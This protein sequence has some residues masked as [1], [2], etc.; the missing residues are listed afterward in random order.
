MSEVLFSA[1]WYRVATLRPHLRGHVQLHRH[2]YRGRLCYV[3]QDQAS[4][5]VHRFSPAAHEVIGLMDGTRTVEAVWEAASA[6]LGDAAPTQ[7]D[8]IQLLRQLHLADVLQCDVP[9]DMAELL[10]RAERQRRQTWQRQLLNPWCIRLPLCDPERLLQRFQPWIQRCFGRVGL[11]LWLL[12]VGTGLLLTAMHWHDLTLDAMDHILSPHNIVLLWLVFPALKALHEWGHACATKA[13]GGEVHDMGLLLMLGI[14][15]PYVDASAATAFRSKWQRMIVGAAGMIVELFLASLALFM[16]LLIEPGLVRALLY[17]VIVIAGISTVLFN[18]NPL[19][20]YDGYYILADYLEMPNLR[21]RASA[22]LRYLWERYVFG[23]HEAE[24]ERM[25]PSERG[26]YVG[27]ALAAGLYRAVLLV[28]V[29]LYIAEHFL[30]AGVIFAASGLIT[31]VLTP[32]AN[33]LS[34]LVMSPRLQHVRL[35][36]IGVMVGLTA[37]AVWGIGFAPVPLRSLAQGVIWAPEGARVRATADGFVERLVASPGSRVQRGDVLVV[38]RDPVLESRVA[39]MQGRVQ[40]LAV[41]YAIEW[42][43]D[44]SQAEILKEERLLWEERLAQARERL[45]A[46]TLRS[47]AEGLFIVPQAADLPGQFVKRGAQLGYVLDQATLTARVVVAQEAIDLVRQRTHGIEVR[48]AERLAEPIP[49]VLGR[50]VPAATQQLPSPALSSQGGGVI[51]TEARD[52]QGTRTLT[53]FFQLDVHLP[54]SQALSALGERV[55]VR[56][57]HGQEPL[58]QRWYR[59]LRGLFLAR[60]AV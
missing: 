17:D 10:L 21:V 31:S 51:A 54:S 47:P 15:C 14:P 26:W 3:L 8:I 20:R 13:Y 27:Y 16:W 25:T 45:A 30:I 50:T 33:L 7:D 34:Y 46:L 28:A 1:V 18:G 24:V 56:F 35:R 39:V 38:C 42:L 52:L 4:Q 59:Q 60:L 29:A 11:L 9:P 48:L 19:L 44:V 53:R 40:E 43:K 5:R 49:A 36:A 32:G 12:V 58:A 2:H 41:R 57:D 6:R 23:C 37:L 55:Y 22:Y